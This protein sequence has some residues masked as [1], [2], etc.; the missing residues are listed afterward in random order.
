MIEAFEASQL[1]FPC[2]LYV[3]VHRHCHRL[4]YVRD[5]AMFGGVIMLRERTFLTGI[6]SDD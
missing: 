2:D 5:I 3:A 4:A 6:S 1:P